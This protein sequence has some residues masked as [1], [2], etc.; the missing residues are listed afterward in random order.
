[1]DPSHLSLPPPEGPEYTPCACDHIKPEHSDALFQHCLKCGCLRYRPKSNS[2]RVAEPAAGSPAKHREVYDETRP[3]CACGRFWSCALADGPA[4]GV[5]QPDTKTR[6]G[7]VLC[8]AATLNQPHG[9]HRWAPQPGMDQVRCPGACNCPHPDDE[10][11]VYG[12]EDGCA[13]EYLPSPK[14]AAPGSRG[15]ETLPR[16]GDQFETWLKAQ[17][18]ACFGHASTWAAVDGLL[19]QYRLHADTGTPLGEHVCEGKAVG[20]CACLEVLKGERGAEAVDS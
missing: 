15:T 17:R 3:L 14:V 9:P 8:S 6:Y 19:D 5:R 10:H 16:R 7:I 1:M 12:C 4:A 13:C 11:S 20:D 18:D 2:E